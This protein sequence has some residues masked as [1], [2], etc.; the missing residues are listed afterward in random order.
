MRERDAIVRLAASTCPPTCRSAV[1]IWGC[2]QLA[3]GIWWGAQSSAMVS[4][5]ATRSMTCMVTVQ[6]APAMARMA[7]MRR[8]LLALRL[9][10]PEKL[11][12]GRYVKRCEAT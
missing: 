7:S 4:M 1:T 3:L 12:A 11:S 6:V 2:A 5:A 10:Q 8:S 9:G